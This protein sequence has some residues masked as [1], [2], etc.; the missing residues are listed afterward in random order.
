MGKKAP[1]PPPFRPLVETPKLFAC[2][3]SPPAC[4]PQKKIPATAVLPEV[5]PGPDPGCPEDV[6]YITA[7]AGTPAGTPAQELPPLIYHPAAP[8]EGM[9][10]A[11][12]A[13]KHTR[14][15][16]PRTARTKAEQL[17]SGVGS[18]GGRGD[19]GLGESWGP[20]GCRHLA[21]TPATQTGAVCENSSR[22]LGHVRFPLCR[23]YVNRF[24]NR[25][26]RPSRSSLGEQLLL[27]SFHG[28]AAETP[29]GLTASP[30]G[31]TP[32]P[33]L[34]VAKL[35][36]GRLRPGAA[37]THLG[38]GH[39]RE[40]VHLQPGLLPGVV[41]ELTLEDAGSRHG[42]DTHPCSRGR[43]GLSLS[44]SPPLHLGHLYFSSLGPRLG[45]AWAPEHGSVDVALW[46]LSPSPPQTLRDCLAEHTDLLG[47]Q[48]GPPTP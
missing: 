1:L 8:G 16:V 2:L 32:L 6:Q 14:R 11:G 7:P 4:E 34:G 27:S 42:G 30:A 43:G 39:I 31:P 36:G 12:P 22:P 24:L 10:A 17:L 37:G 45:G 15:G 35:R 25:R 40:L 48:P 9:N 3:P 19:K 28:G 20:A 47:P 13:Q 33:F 18:Q 29:G 44:G 41:V 26:L 46:P 38:E 21:W 23:L 5:S